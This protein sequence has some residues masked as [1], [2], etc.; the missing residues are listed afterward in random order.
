MVSFLRAT[1]KDA[2]TIVSIGKVS[3]TDAHKDSCSAVILNE[4]IEK[5]Y[6]ENSIKQE[7]SNPDNIYHIIHYNQQAVGFSK[8]VF[9]ASHPNIAA[10]RV[11]KLDRIYLDKNFQGLKLGL[12]LL[13]FNIELSLQNNQTGMWLFTWV[14]NKR[15]IDFYTNFGFTVIGSHNFHVSQEHY[16]LNHH[17]FIDFSVLKNQ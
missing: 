12:Q 13:Q 5:N 17:M 3:V 1:E 4:Y 6:H 16:N 9:D 7:L 2:N 14:G 11:T 10:K 8:I 15:A